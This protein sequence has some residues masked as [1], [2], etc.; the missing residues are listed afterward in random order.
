LGII[1]E[2]MPAMRGREDEIYSRFVPPKRTHT[3]CPFPSH[4]DRN[5]SFRLDSRTGR[6]FCTC[7]SGDVL[8]FIQHIGL[9]HHTGAAAVYVRDALGLPPIAIAKETPT[10]RAIREARLAQSRNEAQGRATTAAADQEK[11]ARRQLAKARHLW[12]SSIV[13]TGTPVEAYLRRRRISC[14]IPRTLRGLPPGHVGPFGA[15][16][17]PFG[18]AWEPEPGFLDMSS[19]DVHCIHLTFI[20]DDAGP[21]CNAR[22]SRKI[23]IGLGHDLPIVLAPPNDGLGLAIAEGIEDALSAH[24]STG[25]GAWAAGTA[26]RLPGLARHVPDWIESCTI[27]VDNDE[28]GRRESARLIR[29]LQ[30]RSIEVRSYAA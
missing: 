7:G 30:G 12:R 3:R 26:N 27:L 21:A 20:T 18:L 15:M 13:A 8:D 17:A 1:R 24:E 11:Y 2:T 4:E 23:T 14:P 22:G 16:I 25:L 29:M 5:P 6:W 19:F 28:A 10:Q 9:A